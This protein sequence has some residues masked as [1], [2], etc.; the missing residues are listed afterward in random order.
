MRFRECPGWSKLTPEAIS[1][2][3]ETRY[4][5]CDFDGE[6]EKKQANGIARAVIQDEL[7][8]DVMKNRE[9]LAEVFCREIGTPLA[10]PQSAA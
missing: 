10:A 5:D 3:D 6:N 1:D 9:S 8:L 2:R 4:L 7:G